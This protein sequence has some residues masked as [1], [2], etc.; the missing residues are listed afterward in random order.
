[1]DI[2]DRL[3]ELIK[4]DN[5]SR[6][7]DENIDLFREFYNS[8]MHIAFYENDPIAIERTIAIYKYLLS[9]NITEDHETMPFVNYNIIEDLNLFEGSMVHSVYSTDFEVNDTYCE[10]LFNL[11]KLIEEF[12]SLNIESSL[13]RLVPRDKFVRDYTG[14]MIMALNKGLFD[15]SN[16][17]ILAMFGYIKDNEYLKKV[18]DEGL[19]KDLMDKDYIFEYA[20]RYLFNAEFIDDENLENDQLAVALREAK[21]KDFE[22]LKK[23]FNKI[24]SGMLMRFFNDGD[25]SCALNT[26]ENCTEDEMRRKDLFNMILSKSVNVSCKGFM[27]FIMNDS[28][29]ETYIDKQKEQR[30][31]EYFIKHYPDNVSE[32]EIKYIISKK[33]ELNGYPL[34]RL[35]LRTEIEAG[36]VGKEY[37]SEA[38]PKVDFTFQSAI[39]FLQDM[40]KKNTTQDERAVAVAIKSIAKKLTGDKVRVLFD[41]NSNQNGCAYTDDSGNIISLNYSLIERLANT[42]NREDDPE[43]MKVFETLFHELRHLVQFNIMDSEDVDEELFEMYKEDTV[44][45][46]CSN[47][48]DKNYFGISFE[49]DARI[50]GASDAAAFFKGCFPFME[51]TIAYYEDRAKQEENEKVV[52]E[53]RIFELSENHTVDEILSKLI[54]INS[55]VMENHPSLRKGFNEDGSKKNT[56]MEF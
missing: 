30:L 25:L 29:K 8:Y 26:I 37:E 47:F 23:L 2:V 42:E 19:G 16:E 49:R 31:L 44:V 21:I 40:L 14:A 51:K 55:S 39:M 41:L 28:R 52:D 45:E 1:M 15:L 3:Y 53:K 13:N 5:S 32:E 48:Y 33:S 6:V 50:R 43:S 38:M 11:I 34:F 36:R 24:D 12:R 18:I 4:S 10:N 54:S 20:T 22:L 7:F 35:N 9:L 27:S 17:K 56:G 46:I